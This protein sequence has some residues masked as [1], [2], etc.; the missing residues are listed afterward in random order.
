MARSG[1]NWNGLGTLI[2]A[3]MQGV[4]EK[5]SKFGTAGV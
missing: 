2:E 3:R 1:R 5:Q 4:V